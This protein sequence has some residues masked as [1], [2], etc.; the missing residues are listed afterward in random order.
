[1]AGAVVSLLTGFFWQHWLTAGGAV[2]LNQHL[3]GVSQADNEAPVLVTPGEEPTFGNS[4]IRS[5]FQLTILSAQHRL[6]LASPYLL[7]DKA[8]CSMLA[9]VRQRGVDV[10]ILTMGAKSVKPMCI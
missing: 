2:N 1:M 7:P 5:L 8:T 3:T 10:R 4:P 9:Q 6:W